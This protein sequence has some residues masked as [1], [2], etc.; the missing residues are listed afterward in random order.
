MCDRDRSSRL[1]RLSSRKHPLWRARAT[2]EFDED[3]KA[4]AEKHRCRLILTHDL[5]SFQKSINAMNRGIACLQDRNDPRAYTA[6]VP[7]VMARLET[8]GD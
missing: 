7:E 5:A 6:H 4:F 2:D 8:L 3:V 1:N